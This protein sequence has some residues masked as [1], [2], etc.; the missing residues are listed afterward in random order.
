MTT[1]AQTTDVSPGK[2]REEIE[3][4]LLR[5]GCDGFRYTWDGPLNANVLEFRLHG[6]M[7][8]LFVPMP[9]KQDARVMER[10]TEIARKT[11]SS[12]KSEAVYEQACR[13]RWRAMLLYV[14]AILEAIE[15]GVTTLD[16]ALLSG[17]VLP[18]GKTFG[19]WATPQLDQIALE[20]RM[21]ELL[22]DPK[23]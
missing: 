10:L 23:S 5:Y 16:E 2:S 14:K 3:T 19:Q 9:D 22:P 12:T 13:Q 15:N 11:K 4:T 17:I 1:Y 18:G 21:P 6:R 7:V 20:G 8:R